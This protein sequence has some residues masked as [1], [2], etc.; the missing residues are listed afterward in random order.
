MQVNGKMESS[1]VR[2]PM[3]MPTKIATQ[4]GTN[5]VRNTVKEHTPIVKQVPN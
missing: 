1:M 2:A 4:V 5:S 3:F